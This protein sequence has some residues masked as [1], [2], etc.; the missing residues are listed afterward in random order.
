MNYAARRALYTELEAARGSKVISYVTSSRPGMQVSIAADAYPWFVEHLDRIGVVPKISLVLHTLGGHT[1]AAVSIMNLIRHFCDEYEVIIPQVARSA[2]TIMSL[3][4]T[5]VMMTKQATLGPID[6]SL[7]PV[8]V[9]SVQGY[10]D[11]ACEEVK[12][13]DQAQR[14][15]VFLKLSEAVDPL[16]IGAAARTRAQIQML[17][18]K[19]LEGKNPELQIDRIISFL[20]SESG[21]HDYPIH[22]RE[23]EALGLPIIKP[24]VELYPRLKELSKAIDAD[25]L[26][27]QPFSID[28][29]MGADNSKDY[30]FFLALVESVD[31]GSDI[32]M[33][34]GTYTV[35][36]NA[37][38]NL[39]SIQNTV[40]E[41]GWR[42][43][44]P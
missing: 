32:C 43:F 40:K 44:D 34:E 14:A 41:S 27:N 8:S 1:M 16:V 37:D 18:R 10:L 38:P 2:G 20:C 39:R 9:E 13:T 17:A 21:S 35:L 3:G 24:S 22:R 25:F 12:I 23:A 15:Q 36:P 28:S 29:Y 31:G 5:G 11:F 42:H 30:K 33:N 26:F 6:P 4:A 19:M 7:G